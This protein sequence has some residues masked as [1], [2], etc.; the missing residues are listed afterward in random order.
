MTNRNNFSVVFFFYSLFRRVCHYIGSSVEEK[1]PRA[2]C[3]TVGAFIF[4]RFFNPAIVSPDSENLCKPIENI[5]I[6]RALLLI[7]KVIQNLAN[8]VLFGAKEPYMNVLNDFL[9]S[10]IVK[11]T[12]FLEEISVS[13]FE[14]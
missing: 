6:K 9:N 3:T 12:T 14:L 5:K 11:I 13:F 4:L 8:N 10:N 1:Y 7:T 2:K